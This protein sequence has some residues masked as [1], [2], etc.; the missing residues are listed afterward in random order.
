MKP[1]IHRLQQQWPELPRDI[2][3]DDNII[4]EGYNK[5]I[6]ELKGIRQEA[7]KAR[8]EYLQRKASM[9]EA[10]E[11]RGKA[12][13]VQ[14]LIRA[15]TQHRIYRK[16]QYLRNQETG[17]QGLTSIKI[18]RNIPI[19]ETETIKKLEDSPE[20]WETI[21]VPQD[22]ETIL[23]DRNKHHFS[24]AEGTPFTR[25]PLNADVKFKADGYAADL[26]LAGQIDYQYLPKA[27]SLLIRH[28]LARTTSTLEGT[29]PSERQTPN[30]A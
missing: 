30:V 7:Q 18:P 26:I 14:R 12:R 10:L 2:P 20:Y 15:G 1:A 24:Q 21:T 5:A 4:K 9:Y 19:T 28:L 29:I 23:L 6:L 13:I 16:L 22:I 11:E 25:P 8:E 27:T 17:S 3:D